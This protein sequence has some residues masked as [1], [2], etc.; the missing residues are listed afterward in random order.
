M[1]DVLNCLLKWTIGDELQ[2]YLGEK[3]EIAQ[4]KRDVTL[5]TTP[6]IGGKDR[7]CTIANCNSIA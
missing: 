5:S 3:W 6:C 1:S 4:L 7:V 2:P